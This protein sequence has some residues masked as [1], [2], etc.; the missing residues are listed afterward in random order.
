MLLIGLG[1][2]AGAGKSTAAAYLKQYGFQEMAFADSLKEAAAA[3]FDLN[4][5]QVHGSLK[6]VPA[7]RIG[8]T[9][10]RIMQEFGDACRSV[11]QEVFI[12]CLR[13][14]L[15]RF[16]GRVV[17]SDVRFLNE[18]KA[19]EQLGAMLIRIDRPGLEE[20]SG[21]PG[22]ASEHELDGWNGWSTV[23]CNDGHRYDL[24]V[25]LGRLLSAWGVSPLRQE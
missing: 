17:V 16:E 22:H 12:S 21:I 4:H 2:K 6:E 9:P 11:W 3:L 18:A 8:K 19:L 25:K 1:G 15:F 10:R 24:Y 13:R 5:E 23:I 14:R 20:T 7:V